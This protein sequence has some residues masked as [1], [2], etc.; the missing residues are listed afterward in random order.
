MMRC[1]AFESCALEASRDPVDEIAIFIGKWHER[2]HSFGPSLVTYQWS[3]HCGLLR[4]IGT[5]IA[6]R[7][8][9]TW[10]DNPDAGGE[11]RR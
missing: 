11:Q 2:G 7:T 1:R 6:P 8:K 5:A 4:L 9:K 3:K 10:R